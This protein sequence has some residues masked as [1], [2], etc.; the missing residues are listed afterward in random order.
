MQVH[1][2]TE[3]RPDLDFGV[4]V[5]QISRNNDYPIRFEWCGFR[6]CVTCVKIYVHN[7]RNWQWLHVPVVLHRIYRAGARDP[8]T[9]LSPCTVRIVL[10]KR[11]ITFGVY[12]RIG[13]ANTNVFSCLMHHAVRIHNKRHRKRE[14]TSPIDF[15]DTDVTIIRPPDSRKFQESLGIF[16]FSRM[17]T[18]ETNLNWKFIYHIYT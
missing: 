13:T 11:R 5:H 15:N 18:R 17:R 10:A 1:M 8:L 3:G 12:E 4:T 7:R 14:I 6:G 9:L 2:Y 16:I